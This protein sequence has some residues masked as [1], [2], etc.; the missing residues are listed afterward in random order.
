MKPVS[1]LLK[2]REGTLWHARPDDTVFEALQLLA[3]YEVGALMV[4][5]QG[6]LVGVLSERDY[7]RKVGVRNS[8]H[9]STCDA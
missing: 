1:Q 6:R 8:D 3:E 9:G 4:I 5:D 7:T 2:G